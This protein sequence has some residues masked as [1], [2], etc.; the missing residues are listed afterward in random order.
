MDNQ[1]FLPFTQEDSS[2]THGVGLGMSIVK[3]L[4]SLLGGEI[5]VMS[6]ETREL[7]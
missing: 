2:S 4:I 6:E 5:Q 1:L 3:S 7:K